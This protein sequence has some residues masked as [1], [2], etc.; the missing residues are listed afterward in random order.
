MRAANEEIQSSNE[1]LQSTNEELST[2][3]EELQSTNE[4]LTTVNEELQ[5]R[6]QELDAVNNDLNNLL[7]AVNI[8]IFMVDSNLR[9][10]RFN[11]A[12]E[13]LLELSPIDIGRPV[14]HLRG[15]IEVPELE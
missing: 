3:K 2:T 13:R 6:N 7:T 4:E 5:N 8:P 12:A 1:E 15:R 14:A 9:V 10:R 11:S